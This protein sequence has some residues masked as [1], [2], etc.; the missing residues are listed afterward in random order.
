MLVWDGKYSSPTHESLKIF[1]LKM[2]TLHKVGIFNLNHKQMKKKVLSFLLLLFLVSA[3]NNS[4]SRLD[5]NVS[6]IDIEP[7]KIHQYEKA[8]FS[9]DVDDFKSGLAQIGF[10]YDVFLG[11]NWDDTLNLIQL[12][13]YICDTK[14]IAL[15]QSST[16]KIPGLKTIETQLTSGF[17]HY[18]YY[19][20]DYD[21]PYIYS[22]ISGLRFEQPVEYA[23]GIMVIGLDNFLGADYAAYKEF[24]IPKYKTMLM[25]Q[26]YIPVECF[27]AL[28]FPHIPQYNAQ[29]LL[30]EMILMGKIIYF[31]D[32]MLPQFPDYMKIGYSEN[33]YKWCEENESNIWAF[34][35]END[36]L[37]TVDFMA[38]KKFISEGPFT[39][40]FDDASPG[41][42]GVWLG[43][44]II[45]KYMQENPQVK[46]QEML[47]M[48]DA[49]G[50]LQN[51]GYKPSRQ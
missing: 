27:K 46:L 11:D 19:Y 9:I 50:I 43:W 33:E 42:I 25:D 34:L 23:N 44:Q 1:V 8:L 48:K 16:E 24:G 36:L 21:I 49:Q 10:Q 45:K 39:S 13:E 17:K 15:Y 3:C 6:D 38:V 29:T 31:I 2:S 14:I 7:V 28:S 22:Y 32:A 37:Y 4:K 41:R 47:N 51:S 20:P 30:D 12:K 5:I 26:E 18:K 35:I 40:G